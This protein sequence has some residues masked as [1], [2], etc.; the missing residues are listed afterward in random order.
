MSIIVP[1]LLIKVTYACIYV[2][3][4]LTT[5][6]MRHSMRLTQPSRRSMQSFCTKLGPRGTHSH[7]ATRGYQEMQLN[8][9]HVHTALFNL[10]LPYTSNNT[11]PSSF[12]ILNHLSLHLPCAHLLSALRIFVIL[13][14]L[15]VPL[16][17]LGPHCTFDTTYQRPT[18]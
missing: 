6:P 16:I 10:S 9:L 4:V 14:R 3:R 12:V 5:F 13:D 7:K 1:F 2:I 17:A 18:T 8:Q 11:S 15:L